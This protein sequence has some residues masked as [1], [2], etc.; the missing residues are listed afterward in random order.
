MAPVKVIK[1]KSIKKKKRPRSLSKAVSPRFQ[2]NN[3]R[4]IPVGLPLLDVLS[5]EHEPETPVEDIDEKFAH[6]ANLQKNKR[7]KITSKSMKYIS[8]PITIGT[9]DSRLPNHAFRVKQVIKRSYKVG[10]QD[11]VVGVSYWNIYL[12]TNIKG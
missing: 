9:N 5:T 12:Y 2:V 11:V 1:V 7:N 8:N 10:D 4:S 6:M 3:L